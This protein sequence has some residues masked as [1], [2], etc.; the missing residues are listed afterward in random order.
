MGDDRQSGGP[1]FTGF[2]F[3]DESGTIAAVQVQAHTAGASQPPNGT[4]V[5]VVAT[6]AP[7]GDGN[8]W[9]FAPNNPEFFNI[10]SVYFHVSKTGPTGPWS[11]WFTVGWP[12]ETPSRIATF[13][14]SYQPPTAGQSAG[15]IVMSVTT[16]PVSAPTP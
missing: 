14:A 2:T 8:V 6:Q 7:D 4:P 10:D 11:P 12:K 15:T 3:T 5:A 9:T 16:A 13:A 1:S